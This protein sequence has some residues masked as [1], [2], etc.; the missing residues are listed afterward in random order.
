MNI[1]NGFIGIKF[2]NYSLIIFSTILDV[3]CP[4]RNGITFISPPFSVTV[5]AP[6]IVLSAR[7]LKSET[8]DA[9]LKRPQFLNRA[10]WC[11]ANENKSLLETSEKEIA[12]VKNGAKETESSYDFLKSGLLKLREIITE[13]ENP[14]ILNEYRRIFRRSVPLHLRAYISAYLLKEYFAGKGSKDEDK[15]G[16]STLFVSIGKTRKV[17]PRDLSRLF[18][19]T[20]KLPTALNGSIKVLDN[21]SFIEVPD[22]EAER[23]IELLNNS[24]YRGRKITVNYARKK[25]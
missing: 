21:Y 4:G 2:D 8:M 6:T 10:D 13:Q 17:F 15:D 25:S 19:E 7:I 11:Q 18:S 20:L 3:L 23:A 9:I 24:E 22:S 1:W 14:E 16:S 12:K 5:S